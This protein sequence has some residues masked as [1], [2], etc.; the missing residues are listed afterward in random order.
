MGETITTRLHDE[1]A[2]CLAIHTTHKLHWEKKYH[3]GL[4]ACCTNKT[5]PLFKQNFSFSFF[6]VKI[7]CADKASS[8]HI[9]Q[10]L[11]GGKHG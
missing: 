10:P 5:Q 1:A 7:Y 6:S 4:A 2:E 8:I 11:S 3:Y 9:S